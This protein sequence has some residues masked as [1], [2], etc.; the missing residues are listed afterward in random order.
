MVS[1]IIKTIYK[2]SQHL[3]VSD[4]LPTRIITGSVV[5]K[6]DIREFTAHGIVWSDGTVTDHVDNVVAATGYLFDFELVEKGELIPVREN[7]TRLYKN[8]LAPQLADW[9]TL[10]IIGLSQVC[11]FKKS[12]KL[13]TL[14][15]TGGGWIKLSC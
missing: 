7:R 2:L 1:N 14:L 5:V 15:L 4:D 11:D 9:N 12:R 13:C 6:P 10:A 8:M 3:T